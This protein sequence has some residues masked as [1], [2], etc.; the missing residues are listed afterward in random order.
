MR[1]YQIESEAIKAG[2]QPK[3]S[4]KY[5]FHQLA[6]HWIEFHASKKRSMKDDKSILNAHL[7]PF[8]GKMPLHQIT[9]ERINEFE[10]VALRKVSPKTL[11]N[12]LTLLNTML[13]VAMDL[14][15]LYIKP[16]IKKPKLVQSPYKYLQ[17]KSEIRLFLETAKGFKK[18]T[19]E[20][21]S[22]AIFTGMRAGEIAGLR[23]NDI[24]LNKRLI[25]VQRSYDGPTKSGK[26]RV[27][28]IL[29]SLLPVLKHWRLKNPLQVVFP[30]SVGNM[31]QPSDRIFQEVFQ[32]CL[33]KAG[34]NRIKF[35]DLRHTFASH[36]MMNDGSLYRL[37]DILGHSTIKMTEHYA[38]LSPY[39]Y[40]E[41]YGR[42]NYNVGIELSER[43]IKLKNKDISS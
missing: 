21:Y 38:H 24:D 34:L 30:N 3:V 42:L 37:K 19:F 40:Q 41:D 13:N 2:I 39:Y 15:W 31:R 20:F 28:P 25:R 5:N 32:R 17:T 11:H 1:K 35:H 8:F 22:T 6:E 14:N 26:E 27:I 16:K 43:V 7:L 23:W 18:G 33:K 12:H 36:W 9:T 29:D 4:K 10:R